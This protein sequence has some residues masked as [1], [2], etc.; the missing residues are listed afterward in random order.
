MA[1]KQ[2]TGHASR[3]EPGDQGHRL[4]DAALADLEA[5]IAALYGQAAREISQTVAEYFARFQ[6]RDR[7]QKKLV[8]AVINGRVYTEQDYK[9]WRLAQMGRGK[10]FAALRDSLAQRMTDANQVAAA[11]INDATPGIYSLNRNY[12]AY[13]IEQQVGADVGFTLWDE[14]TVKRLIVQQ[15]DLMPYY[16]PRR[17]VRRGID[18]AYGKQQITNQVTSGIL[19][20]ESIP[21][22][23]SRIQQ[24]IPRMNRDSAIRAARTA[25]T[26]AQ[27]GGRYDSYRAARDMGIGLKVKWISTLDNRTRHSHAML[28]GQIQN[29]DVPFEVDGQKILY[30]GYPLAVGSL[31]YNCRCRIVPE[32]DKKGLSAGVRRAK[33]PVTGKDELVPGDMT[34]QEWYAMKEKQHGKG[35]ME[36]AKNKVEKE[37]SD[38]K[39]FQE[40]QAVLGKNAPKTFERFQEL[41]YN[42]G[43]WEAFQSYKRAIQTGELTPLASFKLY[44]KTS[45]EIDEKLIGVT[46]SNGIQITGKSKH[47][48]ARVIG[49]TEQNRSGVSIQNVADALTNPKAKIFPVKTYFTGDTSQK[50]RYN[51]VE[52]SVNPET[53]NLV[54]TN[55]KKAG[56][57]K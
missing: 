7:E 10:R 6:K 54:Q 2:N 5:R 20:G 27:N 51:G 56:V 19:L 9:Q 32:L 1:E 3:R 13:T 43:E 48:I 8:G 15:P 12:A 31:I 46:T 21:K 38:R 47:F 28:D 44:Q 4:T 57:K 17:A 36:T 50:F 55:P 30:P 34:Y 33:D 45:Q 40:Y 26:S 16:P 49:S 24:N 23:A 11:Y 14:Q 18:L 53:G 22:L 39:Q 29:V 37:S 42:K 35:A 41:K 52:V 25:V